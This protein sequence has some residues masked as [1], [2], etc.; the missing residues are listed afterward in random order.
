MLGSL[1]GVMRHHYAYLE[2]AFE[3]EGPIFELDLGPLTA[4]FVGDAEAAEEIFVRRAEIYDKGGEFWDSS[5][6]LLGQGLGASQGDLWKRQHKLIQPGFHRKMIEAYCP[7]ID[8]V[9]AEKVDELPSGERVAV[10]TWCNELLSLLTVRIL[11]GSDSEPDQILLVREAMSE[12]F[13]TVLPEMVLRK[14]PSWVPRPGRGR[15][16]DA[17]AFVDE[18]LGEII[19]E[20]RRVGPS[21]DLLSGLVYA[22]D[23]DGA[24]SDEQLRD[25]TLF[26]YTAGYETTGSSLAWTLMLLA[27]NPDVLARVQTE[28]DT[29]DDRTYLGAVIQEGLRLYPPGASIPRRAVTDDELGGFHVAA[30]R[31]VMVSPWLIH[32]D[33]RWWPDPERFDP[34]RFLDPAEKKRRP[35]LAWVPFGAGQRICLG[36]GLALL[37]LERSLEGILSRYTPVVADDGPPPEAR[38]STT[39]KASKPIELVMTP[40]RG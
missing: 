11:L 5:R 40:R 8:A 34:E 33:P 3:T 29:S 38:M 39:L 23:E 20:K 22:T 36:K 6:E 37:E 13:A 1:V 31:L 32:R 28:I 14:L 2:Q 10:D 7:M 24:M 9:V 17:R 19:A 12:L 30:D 16:A 35:R 21:D 26:I 4:L 25:E 15:M 27:R 18:T